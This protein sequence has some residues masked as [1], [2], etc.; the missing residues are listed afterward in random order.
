VL[1]EH[2]IEYELLYRMYSTEGSPLR[3]MYN[4]LEFQKFK[5]EEVSSWQLVTGVVSTSAREERIMR[6]AA[7]DTPMMVAPNAVNVDYFC[8]SEEPIGA[9]A[10]VMTA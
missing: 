8:P 6:E 2:N 1:D 4:W 3:R 7:P 10:L 9:D 5:R